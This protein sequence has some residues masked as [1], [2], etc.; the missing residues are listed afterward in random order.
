M[1]P[2]AALGD[3][4]DQLRADRVPFVEA[5]VVRAQAPTSARPGDTAVVRA[6]GSIEGFV[7]GQCT[8]A[9]VVTAALDVLASGDPLLLRILPDEGPELPLLDQRDAS[10]ERRVVNPC[11]SGGAVEVF[12]RP[13]RPAPA[14]HV[15]GSSPVALELTS[16]L[17]A[18]GFGAQRVDGDAFDAAGALA[19]IVSTH[20]RDEPETLRAALDAEVPFIGLVASERRGTAVLDAMDLDPEERRRIRTP[21]GLAI[22]ARTHA[23][24]ALSVAAELVREVRLGGLVPPTTDTP[25]R[26]TTA[27]DPICGMTVTVTPSTPHLEHEGREIWF[28]A[29]GCRERFAADLVVDA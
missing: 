24:I 12:L 25:P 21:V 10:G 29:P 19:V 1:T 2:P 9:S 15:V 23:E 16:T 17:M 8:E 4:R 28:C 26:P 14:V 27:I 5:T 20:G 11:L 6:D 22:G 7:G 3:L 18:L 13:H